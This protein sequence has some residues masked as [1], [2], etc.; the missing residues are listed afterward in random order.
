MGLVI[1]I[2]TRG[3]AYM[4]GSEAGQC[5]RVASA[6]LLVNTGRYDGA[7]CREA[8]DVLGVESWVTVPMSECQRS[9]DTHLYGSEGWVSFALVAARL[10]GPRG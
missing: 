5:V 6:P 4:P 7:C 9:V 3:V 8:V 1:E 2:D 10:L